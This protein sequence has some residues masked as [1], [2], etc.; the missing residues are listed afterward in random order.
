MTETNQHGFTRDEIETAINILDHFRED[1]EWVSDNKKG[2]AMDV[3]WLLRMYS[4]HH[5]EWT[6][7]ENDRLP[8]ERVDAD[9]F[10][11]LDTFDSAEP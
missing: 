3:Q 7:N 4:E 6:D 11:S 10:E 8:A 9:D 2:S 1:A 5:S